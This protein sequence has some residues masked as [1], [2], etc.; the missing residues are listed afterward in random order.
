MAKRPRKKT[1]RKKQSVARKSAAAV[2]AARKKHLARVKKL[3]HRT[4]YQKVRRNEAVIERPRR[5]KVPSKIAYWAS[6]KAGKP[7]G[8]GVPPQGRAQRSHVVRPIPTRKYK[9]PKQFAALNIQRNV[10]RG[11][12]R[13]FD[14]CE[15]KPDS[16]KAALVR[17]GG[18]GGSHTEAYGFRKWC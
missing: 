11:S 3:T 4:V 18:G 12:Y 17:H 1:N 7:V 15:K 9:Q 16:R 8:R 5:E 14:D 13:R 10:T 2:A 6:T